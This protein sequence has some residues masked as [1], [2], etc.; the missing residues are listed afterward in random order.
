LACKIKTI[1]RRFHRPRPCQTSVCVRARPLRPFGPFR[2]CLSQPQTASPALP[3][4][5]IGAPLK[6]PNGIPSSSPGLRGH[7]L[8]RVAVLT[9][10]NS[11]GVA[12]AVAQR[13]PAHAPKIFTHPNPD[14][15]RAPP[16]P[17][18]FSK[19]PAQLRVLATVLF[20]SLVRPIRPIR[21][22]RLR[23]CPPR[24]CPTGTP[25]NSPVIH[26]RVT[27]QK[28]NQSRRDG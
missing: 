23:A 4:F 22:I 1:Y 18:Q 10:P 6:N 2:P 27:P 20:K 21:P 15:T 9:Q 16:E 28:Q 8:P 12:S 14:A 26:R 11:E 19:L 3:S 17:P 13:S 25:D 5:P 7:E 24:F